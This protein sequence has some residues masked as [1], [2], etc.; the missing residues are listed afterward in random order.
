MNPNLPISYIFHLFAC[1]SVVLSALPGRA[2]LTSGSISLAYESSYITEGRNALESGGL[3]SSMGVVERTTSVGIGFV[4]LWYGSAYVDDYNELALTGGWVFELDSF[5]IGV[6]YTYLDFPEE[7]LDDHEVSLEVVWT[8]AEVVE[9]F[10]SVVYASDA[11]GVFIET[12]VSGEWEVH[13]R[14]ILSPYMALGFNQGY[15]ADG[16]DGLNHVETGIAG[17]FS[18]G[19]SLSLEAFVARVFSVD[20]QPD[21]YPEDEDLKN[22][23]LIGLSLVSHF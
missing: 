13:P 23:L 14:I 11:D 21:R 18:L 7:K 15:V 22:N 12:G 20:A 17:S 2:D 5:V 19:A 1:A 10:L 3:I 4:E 6:A 16:H 9:P 8:S